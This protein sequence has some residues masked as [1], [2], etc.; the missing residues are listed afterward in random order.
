MKVST[1]VDLLDRLYPF[2]LAEEWDNV[3]LIA[4]DSRAEVAGVLL[5][6]DVTRDVLAEAGTAGCNVVITHHPVIFRPIRRLNESELQGALVGQA[7][8]D[9]IA[10]IAL[11]TN[12]D[13]AVGGLNDTLCDLLGLQGVKP[14]VDSGRERFYK[15]A[16]FVPETHA[17]KVRQALFDGGAGHVGNYDSCSFNTQGVGTFRGMVGKTS[18]FLG[19]PG[20]LE[21]A[22]EIK[23]EVILRRE[24]AGRVVGAMLGAHPYEEVA[25]DLIPLHN[26]ES[27]TGLARI[28]K[29]A[30]AETLAAFTKRVQDL[31]IF[32]KAVLG[33]PEKRVQKVALCSGAGSDFCT[34]ALSHGAD[35]YLTAELKHHH[36]LAAH[37]KGM[38]LVET[39][40]YTLEQKHWPRLAEILS[41]QGLKAKVSERGPELWRRP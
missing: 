20:E 22:Q 37:D 18:P 34:S 16:V 30:Q 24:V 9:R 5:A 6:L 35:V 17:D 11:H 33:A 39:D 23:I 36:A 41:G 2:A 13:S 12:L 21:R 25:Y 7:L 14:L 19:T 3:G 31:G 27:G 15:L 28:G 40:H 8:R 29:L 26:K 10:L 4:G 32:V 38:A 1:L